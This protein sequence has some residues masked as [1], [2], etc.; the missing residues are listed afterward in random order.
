MNRE[1][2]G[3]L[4]FQRGRIGKKDNFWV[5]GSQTSFKVYKVKLDKENPVCSC[6]DCELRKK[7][8]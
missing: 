6:P 5:V 2:R 3:K 8:M 7:E 4:I 1:E